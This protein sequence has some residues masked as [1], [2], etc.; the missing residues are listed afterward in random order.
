MGKIGTDKTCPLSSGVHA[1]K[2]M[3]DCEWN[4][5]EGCAVWRIVKALEKTNTDFDNVKQRFEE[6]LPELVQSMKMERR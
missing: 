3:D 1:I 2:C 5:G 4:D 6:I